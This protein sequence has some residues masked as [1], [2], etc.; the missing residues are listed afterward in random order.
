MYLWRLNLWL[1]MKVMRYS[2]EKYK[3]FKEQ[4][5]MSKAM[6]GYVRSKDSLE[7]FERYSDL[8]FFFKSY[9]CVLY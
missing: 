8:H 2:K 3:K 7:A 5:V 6:Y 4:R 1:W 9:S